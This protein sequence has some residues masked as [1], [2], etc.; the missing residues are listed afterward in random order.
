MRL[1]A[2][3]DLHLSHP[4]NR[5]AL[6]SL[7]A[8]RDDWLVLPGDVATGLNRLDGCFRRLTPKFRQVVWV[9]GNHEL[10]TVPDAVPSLR[11]VALYERLVRI[12]RAH[13]VLTPEDPYPVV[14][15]RD[16]PVLLA[17]LFLLYD[18][19]FRPRHVRRADV[20]RWARETGAVCADEVALHP[21]PYPDRDSWCAVRCRDAAARLAS[22]PADLPKVLVNHYPLEEEHAVLPRIPRFTPWC[23][24]RRTRGWHRR[25]NACAVV[26][27]HL[28]IRGIRWLDGVPFQ[29]TS[30]GY[31]KQ[32]DRRRGVGAYLHE[33][34]LAPRG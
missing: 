13:G 22:C 2:L 8:F 15:L 6:E 32:W 16:G 34:T 19:S 12:A 4:G 28:H 29:E 21:D 24:T 11:G 33:V 18:Y 9:P 1:L 3:S 5:E 27:G 23:G 20:V 10:W 25:F 17:P 14:E 7:P 26:Y 30:L 31:P